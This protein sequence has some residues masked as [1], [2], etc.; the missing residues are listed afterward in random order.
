[1]NNIAAIHNKQ[2]FF[3]QSH[4]ALYCF[5]DDFFKLYVLCFNLLSST[6]IITK[7]KFTKDI[8]F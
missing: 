3:Y 7:L 1:M 6:K 2:P 5:H 4:Y 8:K